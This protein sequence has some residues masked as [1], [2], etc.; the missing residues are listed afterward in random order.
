MPA[1]VTKVPC[2][3]I[4]GLE[5]SYNYICSRTYYFI[6]GAFSLPITNSLH[7][8][9]EVQSN[10]SFTLPYKHVWTLLYTYRVL[11]TQIDESSKQL[12][13]KTKPKHNI[14]HAVNSSLAAT[15]SFAAANP[16]PSHSSHSTLPRRSSSLWQGVPSSRRRTLDLAHI[17]YH[18]FPFFRN[19]TKTL[20]YSQDI[21]ENNSQMGSNPS[22]TKHR[23]EL[24]FF[25]TQT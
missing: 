16:R 3:S 10:F 24:G 11:I 15:M 22:K 2:H 8:G 21:I 5:Q 25:Q 9:G 18:F 23:E 20:K 17:F 14:F 1:H 6:I 7:R 4:S 12:N 13:N 19:Q